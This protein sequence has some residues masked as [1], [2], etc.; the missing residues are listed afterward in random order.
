MSNIFSKA[1]GFVVGESK[2]SRDLFNRENGHLKNFGEWV[3]NSKFTA[4]E[5]AELDAETAKGVRQFAIDTLHENTDRSKSRRNCAQLIIRSYILFIFCSCVIYP[6]N[7][8]AAMFW[9]DVAHKSQL[10]NL[11]IAVSVFFW[12][13]HAFRT[14]KNKSK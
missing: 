14:H 4:E 9:F 5:M 6:F 3:G 12:G 1:L 8:D 13:H 2:T 7:Q 10:G 11:T